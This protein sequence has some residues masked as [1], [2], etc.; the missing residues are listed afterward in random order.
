MSDKHMLLKLARGAIGE[1]LGLAF[2][3]TLYEKEAFLESGAS[4]VT[5]TKG[6]QL[7]GCIG[8]LIAT[9]PLFEDVYKNA[10]AAAFEDPRF[11]PVALDELEAITVEVSLLTPPVAVE[12]ADKEDLKSKI[13][14]F[15]DGVIL[16]KGYFQSTFLPQVWEQLPDFESFFAHLCAKGGMHQ[17]CIDQDLQVFTYQVEKFSEA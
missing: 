8:S 5:L 15:K 7:R 12:F 9:R 10:K 6:G 14:P 1:S 3:K 13:T 2:D 4:F 11:P 17:D 16:K